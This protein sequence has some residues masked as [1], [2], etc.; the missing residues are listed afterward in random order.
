MSV[1]P[2]AIAAVEA[3][4]WPRILAEGDRLA[5]DGFFSSAQKAGYSLEVVLLDASEVTLEARRAERGSKQDPSWVKGRVSRTERLRSSW[6]TCTLDAT[7]SVEELA[8]ELKDHAVFR[9][10]E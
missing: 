10:G 6:V 8:M 1:S 4:M 7:L 2:K 5:H 3:H 9:G